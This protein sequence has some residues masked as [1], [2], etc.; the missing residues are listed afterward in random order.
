MEGGESPSEG[1]PVL[2]R[3]TVIAEAYSQICQVSEECREV[4]ILCS[5]MFLLGEDPP[6][7][8]SD[9][10]IEASEDKGFA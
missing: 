4:R 7:P 10:E 3:A 5:P 9:R 8:L 1:L 6:T 2:S